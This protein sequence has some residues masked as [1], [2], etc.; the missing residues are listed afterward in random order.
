MENNKHCK[1]CRV[2]PPYPLKNTCYVHKYNDNADCPCSACIVKV[3]CEEGDCNV[4]NE[5]VK[6]ITGI[7]KT[8][9]DELIRD[10]FVMIKLQSNTK[11]RIVK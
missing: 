8:S 2:P 11:I 9:T 7:K 6:K 4:F 10:M 1:G 3:T 5:Y